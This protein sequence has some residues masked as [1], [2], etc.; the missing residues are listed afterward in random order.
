M[1]RPILHI[2]QQVLVNHFYKLNAA[3]FL[4]FFFLLFG[5]VQSGQIINYHLSLIQ[6]MIESTVF[7]ACVIITWLLYTLKCINYTLKQL[8]EPEQ[9]FLFA[10]NTLDTPGQYLSMLF[11]HLQIYL[12]VLLYAL[13]VATRASSQHLYGAMVAV[14]VSNAI[15][16]AVSVFIYVRGVQ[17]KQ[18]LLPAQL[19][20]LRW[21]FRKPFFTVILWFV[22]KERKQMLLVTK[23][24]SFLLLYGFIH[25]YEPDRPDIRPLLLIMMLVSVLHCTMVFHMRLFE[26]IFLGFSRNLPVRIVAR[27]GS[28]CAGYALLLLPEWI[29]AAQAFPIHFSIADIPQL[30]LLS[31]ALPVLFHC[32]LLVDDIN[33]NGYFRIV[34]GIAAV[35][36]FVVLYDPGI[37]LPAFILVL[38]FVFFN[39][40]FYTFER[41][42]T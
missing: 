40:H 33:A 5:V 19:P 12:P 17:R 42:Y 7:L 32:L 15:F 18:N 39:A 16:I 38:S 22:W 11:V 2:L 34:A 13:I 24:G 41:R 31:V 3:F 36:F 20:V 25:L 10:L 28:L 30:L 4:F 6:G 1:R 37:V 21:P 26:E 9:N 27:F 14:L 23:L 35:L 29:F 8:R